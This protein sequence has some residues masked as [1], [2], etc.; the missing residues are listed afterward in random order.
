MFNAA[1]NVTSRRKENVFKKINFNSLF[2]ISIGADSVYDES[3]FRMNR[4]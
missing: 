4:R 2:G 3:Y 1:S